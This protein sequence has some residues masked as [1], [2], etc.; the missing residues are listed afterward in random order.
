MTVDEPS[1]EPLPPEVPRAQTSRAIARGAMRALV[2]LPFAACFFGIASWVAA[3]FAHRFPSW[4]PASFP[5]CFAVSMVIWALALIAN[6]RRLERQSL[7]RVAAAR[8]ARES[9]LEGEDGAYRVILTVVGE[10]KINVIKIIRDATALG[11]KE[12]KDLVDRAP[13]PVP[14]GFSFEGASKLQ[15]ALQQ[16]GAQAEVQPRIRT[17]L[18]P[19]LNPDGN[20]D[21]VAPSGTLPNTN[22]PASHSRA[23]SG[24]P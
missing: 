9:A 5:V 16:A 15:A 12:A 23:G 11:L 18:A 22:R 20:G 24:S 21:E 3:G 1:A 8:C 10:R 13:G 17:E 14:Q 4:L 2:E 7:T 6:A 19:A